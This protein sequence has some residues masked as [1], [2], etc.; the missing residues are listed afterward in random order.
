VGSLAEKIEFDPSKIEQVNGR[1][2]SIYS[3]QQKHRVTTIHELITL[4]YSFDNKINQ[5]VGYGDEIAT[6]EKELKNCRA[7][8]EKLSIQLSEIRRKS[9]SEIEKKVVADLRQLGMDKAKLGVVHEEL[10]DF[11]PVGKDSVSFLFSAN[12][13]S[14]AAEISRIASGGEMSRLMLAIK[15][16]LRNS[17]ALPTLVFDEIDSGVSGEIAVKMGN[18]LKSFSR[19]AQILNITHLPQIAAKGD[20]H[21]MVYKFEK[22]GKT[23]TSIKRL[24]EKERVEEL[25]KMVSGEGVTD[26]T[27]KTAQELLNS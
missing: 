14:E 9:F 6:L 16:L 22:E 2:N 21:F 3:L 18:I 8:L 11:G 15:N 13:D 26:T 27:L 24:N 25:A 17:K 4:K 5:A 19:S 1:L 20:A 7:Q 10:P 12:S 23:F